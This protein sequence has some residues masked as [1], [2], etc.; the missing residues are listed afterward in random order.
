MAAQF[1]KLLKINE[2]SAWNGWILYVKRNSIKFFFKKRILV[3]KQ[4]LMEK[5]FKSLKWAPV[6]DYWINNEGKKP[7]KLTKQVS[8]HLE[9]ILTQVWLQGRSMKIIGW[10]K[11]SHWENKRDLQ[12]GVCIQI[13]ASCVVLCRARDDAEFK[14]PCAEQSDERTEHNE[15]MHSMAVSDLR[16]NG[17]RQQCSTISSRN[18]IRCGLIC[19]WQTN[20]K[21]PAPKMSSGPLYGHRNQFPSLYFL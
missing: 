17:H 12:A 10:K 7:T 3:F 6:S 9:S 2:L 13:L 16:T 19:I 1:G 15:H 8:D 18:S 4:L 21:F 14:F 5:T 11:D 20:I